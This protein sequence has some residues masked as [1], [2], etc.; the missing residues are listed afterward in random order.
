M[1]TFVERIKINELDYTANPYSH[2]HFYSTLLNIIDFQNQFL[3]PA[4]VY[5]YP[6]PTTASLHMLTAQELLYHPTLDVDMEPA[7]NEL[8]DMTIF[9][10]NIAKLVPSTEASALPTL[11]A[12]ADLTATATQITG[13]LKLMLDET[14]TLAPVPIYESTMVQPTAM[15]AQSNQTTD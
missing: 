13:F 8:L 11:T 12:T 2:F 5:A 14:W 10:S 9:D 4:P 3:F 1:E 7:D 15:D 6:L